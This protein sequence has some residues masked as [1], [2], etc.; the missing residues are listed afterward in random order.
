MTSFLIRRMG[1]SLVVLFGVS[2]IVFVII[3]LLPGGPAAGLLGQRATPARVHQFIV[4]NGYNRPLWVQYVTYIGQL[5]RGN[6]GYSYAYNQSVASLLGTALPRTA[7]LVGVSVAVALVVA[8]PMGLFQAVRRN[9][10]VDHGLTTIAFIGYSLPTFWLGIVLIIVFA[11]D[12]GWLPAEGPQSGALGPLDALILP[13]ATLAIVTVAQFSRYVRSAAIDNLVQEYV[14]TARAK[15]VPQATI[16]RHHVLRNS[17]L[18]IITLLGLSLPSIVAGAVVVE[19]L[20]NYPG[21]GLLFW[22]AASEHDYPLLM[23]FTIVVGLA[24][25]IGNLLADIAYGFADPRIRAD[26]A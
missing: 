21:M 12:L 16:I 23:G 1:Q 2:L 25:V 14:R 17:L 11:I 3:H 13:V 7:I 15:G 6:L 4:A 26:R 20:F 19:A 5:L 10:L 22:K 24:T 9:R 18:P 8:I